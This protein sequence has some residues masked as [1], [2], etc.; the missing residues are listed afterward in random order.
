MN[1]E[2]FREHCLSVKGSSESLPFIGND[3]LVFKIMGKMFA[4]IALEPKDGVFRANMKC[5]PARSRELREHYQGVTPTQ[6]T[7]ELWNSVALESDLSDSL[8]KELLLHSV[9]EVVKKLPKRLQK[10]YSK[11]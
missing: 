8:I 5:N 3:V 7:T 9:E 10:E 1:I 2:E 6:F 11:L 4:Y